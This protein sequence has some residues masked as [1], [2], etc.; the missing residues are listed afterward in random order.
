MPA[1]AEEAAEVSNT[2]VLEC[3]AEVVEVSTVEIC[4]PRAGA[5]I[6]GRD[7]PAPEAEADKALVCSRDSLH[8]KIG[9]KRTNQCRPETEVGLLVRD[10]VGDRARLRG[11]DKAG[12]RAGDRIGLRIGT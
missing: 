4:S 9:A 1:E 10:K 2:Q 7:N 6:T 5:S 3:R 8:R 11:R 12:H